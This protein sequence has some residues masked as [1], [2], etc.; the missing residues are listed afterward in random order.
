MQCLKSLLRI[1][2][3]LALSIPPRLAIAQDSDDAPRWAKEPTLGIGSQAPQLDIEY[4]LSDNDG[5]FPQVKNFESDNIYVIDF[6]S[7]QSPSSVIMMHKMGDLQS[8]YDGKDVQIIS[9]CVEDLDTVEDFLEMETFGPSDEKE[10]KKTFADITRSY[11]LTADPDRSVW[12]D[13]YIA[14]G[15]KQR[16]GTFIVGKTGLIEWIGNSAR[17]TEPLDKIVAGQWDRNEFKK[18]YIEQQVASAKAQREAGKLRRK[19][20]RAMRDI[21]EKIQNGDETAAVDMLAEL[22]EDE[23]LE[24]AKSTFKTMRLQLMITSEHEDAVPAMETFVEEN[25]ADGRTLNSITWAIYELFEETGGD[26]DSE[27]LK[28]ARK[29]AGYAAKAEPKNGAILDT[30]AHYIYIVDED[31][32]RAIEV[33]RKA[34]KNAGQQLENLRPFLTELLREKETGKKKKK[35]K[36]ESDF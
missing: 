30:L 31:L 3:L 21:Q 17:M 34:V 14:S 13:Y 35:N 5:L 18:R 4:W 7:T 22:I 25:K 19:L 11:C 6:W 28:L 8:K 36:V 9:V 33:Q 10:P 15:R 16:L 1:G 2:L 32:D 20:T 27:I 26:V 24:N 29:G 12:N 23:E